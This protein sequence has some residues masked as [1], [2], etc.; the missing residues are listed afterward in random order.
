MIAAYMTQKKW[1]KGVKDSDRKK[2][3]VCH[4]T[5][6]VVTLRTKSYIHV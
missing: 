1:H 5:K 6:A 4:C 2:K 3:I